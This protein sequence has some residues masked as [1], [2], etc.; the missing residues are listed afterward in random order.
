MCVREC[1]C[2]VS[3]RETVCVCV[4]VCMC[5]CIVGGVCVH[6]VWFVFVVCAMCVC[7]VCGVS[8]Y[9][10]G[11]VKRFIQSNSFNSFEDY[12]DFNWKWVTFCLL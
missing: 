10:V 6:C 5:V 11:V 3:D 1:V 12:F 9:Y 4:C 8:V 2:G 7:D